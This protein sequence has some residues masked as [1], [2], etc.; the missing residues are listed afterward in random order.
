MLRLGAVNTYSALTV[1]EGT[2][3]ALVD[4]AIPA[5]IP[6]TVSGTNFGSTAT[7]DFGGFNYTLT[8]ANSLVFGGGSGGATIAT[9]AGTLTLATPLSSI[10]RTIRRP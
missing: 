1:N 6:L 4:G 2:V 3:R 9:G 8:P 10:S 7:L 5:G